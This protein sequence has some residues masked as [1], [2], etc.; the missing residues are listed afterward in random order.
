MF[1]TRLIYQVVEWERRI[2]IENE[3][4]RRPRPDSSADFTTNT[5]VTHQERES[6]FAWVLRFG[7]GR[8]LVARS[9]EP[10]GALESP[11]CCE[12]LVR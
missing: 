7:R 11:V 2:E 12:S 9:V 8:R 4:R 1:D 5:E 10:D 3:K 6:I